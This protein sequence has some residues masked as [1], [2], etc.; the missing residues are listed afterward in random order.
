MAVKLTPAGAIG[1]WLIA[2]VLLMLIGYF[3]IGPNI[4]KPN[5]VE[6]KGSPSSK[7][8]STETDPPTVGKESEASRQAP[9]PEVDVTV[10]KEQETSVATTHP[11]SRLRQKTTPHKPA[12]DD[13]PHQ[14]KPGASAQP[15][16]E[17]GSAGSTTAG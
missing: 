15:P 6:A 12:S 1:K 9:A 3:L 7:V 17:G 14:P 16:D 8:D 4:G 2:P 10:Q 5:R 11:H 13:S